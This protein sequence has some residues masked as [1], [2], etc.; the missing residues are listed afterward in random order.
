MT[1]MKNDHTRSN[2]R[3]WRTTSTPPSSTRGSMG[4]APTHQLADLPRKSAVIST[5]SA[6]GLKM[7]RRRHASRYLEA[8][9][10]KAA[11][12]QERQLGEGRRWVDDIGRV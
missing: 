7:C 9:A 8:L 4:T 12:G 3:I 6:A 5:A 1:A 10:M 2:L 11:Q